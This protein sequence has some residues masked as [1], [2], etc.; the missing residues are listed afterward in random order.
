MKILGDKIFARNENGSLKS[1][2]GTIFLRTRGLVTEKSMHV[3]QRA[4]WIEEINRGRRAQN[5]APLSEIEAADE[6]AESVDL[7]FT[8]DY[9]LIRPD[10]ERMDLAFRADEE[11]QCF[12]SKRKIR[13]L[14]THSHKVRTALLQRG[15]N[16]RIAPM[17]RSSEEMNR[18]IET[19]RASIENEAIYY[20]NPA[21]GTRYFTALSI[22]SI[23][24]LPDDRFAAQVKEI[25]NGLNSCN[26]FLQPDVAVFPRSTPSEIKSKFK[27]LNLN[28]SADE[29]RKEFNAIMIDYRMSIPVNLRNETVENLDWRNEMCKTLSQ[30]PN[31]TEVEDDELINNIS[32]EF[33]R[34]IEWFPGGRID[35][36]HLIF[37]SIYDEALHSQDPELLAIC[38]FRVRNIIFNCMRL[39]SKI[40]YVNVGRISHSLARTP[41]TKANRGNVYILQVKTTSENEE[42]LFILRFQK[43]GIAE[44]LN[45]GK[46]L[47]QSIIETDDYADYILDR[48]LACKQLGMNLP[49]RVSVGQLIEKYHGDNEYKNSNIRVNYFVRDY[50]SGTASDKIPPMRFANPAFARKFA[51]LMGE[52]AALD[53]IVGRAETETGE[54]V[55]DKNHEVIKYGEDSLPDNIVITDHAGAF[56]KY[57][58][59][60][61]ELAPRYA[62]VVTRREKFVSDYPAFAKAFVS[63]F[64]KKLD[65]V[66]NLYAS[67]PRAFDELFSMRPYDEA[68]SAAFRWEKI[69]ERLK[70]CDPAAVADKV[71]KTI[72]SAQ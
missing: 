19:S 59:T 69:L 4:A 14:N 30:R 54:C 55:F 6:I 32:P 25:V 44:H 9:V 39:F 57:L 12:V 46:T 37:D 60:L 34:Q 27:N 50:I 20:Y 52:A 72:Q 18:Q 26:R 10:P 24:S 8:N 67:N 36:G 70:S 49:A 3:L 21:T 48:R 62:S 33:Y 16:W 45:A 22:E 17:P 53:I 31:Q 58:E 64:E 38:D 66:K 5:M 63:S 47:L 41:N 51:E 15:E 7:L 1:R 13:F 68:G 11:L 43:W 40:Q 29:M 23:T 71:R 65:E 2:I 56:V 61:E 35:D 28:L 42:R